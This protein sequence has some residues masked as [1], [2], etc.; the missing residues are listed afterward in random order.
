[1]AIISDDGVTISGM[2]ACSDTTSALAALIVAL[3][4]NGSVTSDEINQALIEQRGITK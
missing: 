3:I 2:M 4:R 1:M